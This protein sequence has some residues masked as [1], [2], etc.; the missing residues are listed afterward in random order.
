VFE[1]LAASVVAHVGD[2]GTHGKT[3]LLTDILRV[4]G[5][6]SL[7]N[8]RDHVAKVRF[9]GQNIVIGHGDKAR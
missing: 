2:K 7:K 9:G 1:D 3:S 8:R 4:L 6:T 5:S